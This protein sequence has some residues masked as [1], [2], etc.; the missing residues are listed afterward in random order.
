ME[1]K[2][3]RKNLKQAVYNIAA[4]STFLNDTKYSKVAFGN[5]LEAKV[6]YKYLYGTGDP[7]GEFEPEEDQR[8]VITFLKNGKSYDECYLS[9][10]DSHK[11]YGE[12][13]K[14]NIDFSVKVRAFL[15]LKPTNVERYWNRGVRTNFTK[16][17]E[18]C[19]F[20]KSKEMLTE[21]KDKIKQSELNN[22]IND[23]HETTSYDTNKNAKK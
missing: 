1:G 8:F 13:D 16:E 5:G 19:I 6:E 23:N 10:H 18:K 11:E 4:I 7:L 20:N 17:E 21:L 15:K 9:R 12:L 22:M 2:D 3:M 14:K